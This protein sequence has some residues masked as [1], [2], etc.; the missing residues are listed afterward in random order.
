M[1]SCDSDE[2]LIGGGFTSRAVDIDKNMAIG[3]T[4]VVS[5]VPRLQAPPEIFQVQAFAHC[6]TGV[7]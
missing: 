7:V 2:I 1:A 6:A 4:W 5:G 3:N